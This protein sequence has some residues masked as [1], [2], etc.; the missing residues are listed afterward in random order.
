MLAN[1][2][3]HFFLFAIF[4]L[5][6]ISSLSSSFPPLSVTSFIALFFKRHEFHEFAYVAGSQCFKVAAYDKE[7]KQKA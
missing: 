3:K 2:E 7:K 1:G 4:Q 5:F 6:F